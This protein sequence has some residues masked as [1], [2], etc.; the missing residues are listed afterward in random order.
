MKAKSFGSSKEG[1]D[2]IYYLSWSSA[3]SCTDKVNQLVQEV[4]CALATEQQLFDSVAI[5]ALWV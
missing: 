1:K 4:T 2:T 3:R 5:L